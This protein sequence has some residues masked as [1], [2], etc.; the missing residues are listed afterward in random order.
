MRG[1]NYERRL[2]CRSFHDRNEDTEHD[3]RGSGLFT[4]DDL[5]FLVQ[6]LSRLLQLVHDGTGNLALRND[7][8]VSLTNDGMLNVV[9]VHR[10][11]LDPRL[12]C[13]SGKL[14]VGKFNEVL[15]SGSRSGN[16]SGSHN[17]YPFRKPRI[18]SKLT[19]PHERDNRGTAQ[20]VARTLC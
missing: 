19:V 12:L 7:A 15:K 17:I 18:S 2:L 14:F 6:S 20:I 11:G 1:L 8:A 10:R 9:F 13:K 4:H 16:G 5:N 3:D